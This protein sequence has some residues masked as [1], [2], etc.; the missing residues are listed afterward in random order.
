M[1]W[2]RPVMTERKKTTESDDDSTQFL[3]YA[4]KRKVKPQT[5]EPHVLKEPR[6]R[7]TVNQKLFVSTISQKDSRPQTANKPHTDLKA[8]THSR[9]FTSD[10][11]FIKSPR[12]LTEVR[13]T[14]DLKLPKKKVS[15]P[16]LPQIPISK[17][18][19]PRVHHLKSPSAMTA[20]TVKSTTVGTQMMTSPN[21]KSTS[22][23]ETGRTTERKG[24]GAMSSASRRNTK[25]EVVTFET[26]VRPQTQ[27]AGKRFFKK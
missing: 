22:G 18:N 5:F 23:F 6:E 17:L 3:A 4:Q 20:M 26:A 2:G 12:V 27:A 25:T 14:E 24:D 10:L 16:N 15:I 8:K 1:D 13:S 21:E 11:K 19:T 9:G 7:Q